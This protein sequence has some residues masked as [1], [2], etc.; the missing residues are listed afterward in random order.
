[1]DY[2]SGML[3]SRL[4]SEAPKESPESFP[5]ANSCLNSEHRKLREIRK[6]THSLGAPEVC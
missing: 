3:D 2:M 4:F 1:M 6:S 5:P